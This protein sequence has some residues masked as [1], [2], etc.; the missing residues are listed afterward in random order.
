MSKI[1]ITK[2]NFSKI[3]IARVSKVLNS[4]WLV[5]GKN[6]FLLEKLWKKFTGAKYCVAVNSCT[7]ALIV[8]LKALELRPGDEVIV[9]SFSWIST[10]NAAY[11]LG[12]KI[13]FCDISLYD[14]NIDI[15]DLKKKISKRTKFIIAVHL[16]GI[17]ANM[18]KILQI[19]R[20]Y[21][22]KVIE[23][24]ACGHGSLI[25]NKHVGNFSLAG[26]FSFHAR[27]II[28]TGEG[29]AV[30]TNNKKIY[31]RCLEL[32]DHG[33]LLNDFTRHKSNEPYIMSDHFAAGYNFRMTDIQACLALSQ[34]K[35]I[36]KILLYR[37]KIAK[38][39]DDNLAKIKWLK[40][41]K[42]PGIYNNAYQSYVLLVDKF[43]TI[44]K[45]EQLRNQLMIFLQS[46]GISTRPGTHAIHELTFYKNKNK[47]SLQN[48]TKA[49]KN[50]ISL[51][52]FNNMSLKMVNKVSKC[53]LQYSKN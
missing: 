15:E 17:P 9:P 40:K 46:K 53:I 38:K 21:K 50:S 48:S 49:Y 51:P 36:D 5:Q 25:K 34:I 16:F 33:A 30:I 18:K 29:G 20:K 37:K 19:S 39:Y 3:D 26:C 32:R 47:H 41:I 35:N 13:K 27:K 6:V 43:K 7:S 1:P 44:Q 31:K 11:L 42:I 24:A 28:T 14:Y 23:D 45:N 22:V 8:A 10:A 12:A 52:I 2:I 4:G